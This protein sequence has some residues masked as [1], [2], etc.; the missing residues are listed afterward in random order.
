MINQVT[1]ANLVVLDTMNLWIENNYS[2]LVE[3]IKKTDILLINDEEIL[4]L[5]NANNIE[6][7]A[8]DLLQFGLEYIIV[9]KGGEEIERVLQF[10]FIFYCPSK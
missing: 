6:N 8:Q 5:T 2:E 7:A 4:Q 10:L 9:K 3:V 1:N